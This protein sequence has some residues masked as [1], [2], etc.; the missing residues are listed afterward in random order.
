MR[1]RRSGRGWR[2]P[3]PRL[4]RKAS[5]CGLILRTGSGLPERSALA[6]GELR[7]LAGLLQ[8]VLAPLLLPGVPGEEPF[9]LELR[10]EGG[11]VLDERSG[12][13]VPERPGLARDA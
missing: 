11:V 3:E 6:L 4:C 1:G 12:D 9:L 8:P 5:S 10:T 7:R 13:A 2:S